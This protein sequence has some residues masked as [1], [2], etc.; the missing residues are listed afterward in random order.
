M[1]SPSYHTRYT[2]HKNKTLNWLRMDTEELYRE[3]LR[4]NYH[5][6][7]N[8]GWI[9]NHFTYSFNSYGFRCKEFTS[10][11]SILFLGCSHT[12]GVGLPLKNI[13]PELVAEALRLQ[14]VNLGIGG[15]SID[16]S[17]RMLHGYIDKI[18]PKIVVLMK[19][20]KMRLEFFNYDGPEN[21]GPW[22]GTQFETH[23]VYSDWITNENNDFFQ[24]EKNL[25][26]INQIC[27]ERN[28]K[29]LEVAPEDY[30]YIDFARD[31]AH[32]GINTHK[33]ISED[34]ITRIQSF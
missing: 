9:D 5:T 34:I 19:P 17:F 10:S 7:N 31:L 1:I 27:K 23:R 32:M 24:R 13:W 8:L 30:K 15:S 16:T 20:E 4:T 12:A 33:I 29:Y 28:I 21:L 18:K 3:N 6:L 11:P 2:R 22:T 25:L 26:A 14:C